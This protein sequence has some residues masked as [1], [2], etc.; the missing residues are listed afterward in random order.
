MGIR[1]VVNIDLPSDVPA[2]AYREL[3]ELLEKVQFEDFGWETSDE[4]YAADGTALSQETIDAACEA[5]VG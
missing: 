5:Y 3:Q 4:W 1:I 2:E